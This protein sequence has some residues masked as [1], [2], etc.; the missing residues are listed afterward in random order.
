M[1]TQGLPQEG[2]EIQFHITVCSIPGQES[3]PAG[4]YEKV[5]QYLQLSEVDFQPEPVLM[6]VTEFKT[7]S[8]SAEKEGGVVLWLDSSHGSQFLTV[9]N[10]LRYNLND[11]TVYCIHHH[12]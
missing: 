7:V 11:V 3:V 12:N 2:N 8:G 10:S 9:Y 4:D 5:E 1:I 6:D